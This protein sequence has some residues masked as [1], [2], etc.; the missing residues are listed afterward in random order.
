M[1]SYNYPLLNMEVG[2]Q[3]PFYCKLI[4][5]QKIMSLAQFLFSFPYRNGEYFTGI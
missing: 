2:T 5:A 4:A 1:I 3:Y